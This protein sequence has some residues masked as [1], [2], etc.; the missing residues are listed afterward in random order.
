MISNVTEMKMFRSMKL[1]FLPHLSMRTAA[2]AASAA[3][4]TLVPVL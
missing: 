4:A 1:E 2:A 3:A